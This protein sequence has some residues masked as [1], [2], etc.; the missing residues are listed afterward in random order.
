MDD[1]NQLIELLPL[2]LDLRAGQLWKGEQAIE[3]RPKPWNLML[4][5]A[6]RPGELL[7]KQEL[8]DAI[9]PDTYVSESSLNQAVKELR[10]ALGDDA[11]SPRFI[12]T[13]HRRGFRLIA[14][15]DRTALT[16]T[17]EDAKPEAPLFGRKMEFEVL[18]KALEAAR[19][20]N[21]QIVFITGEAGIG[22]TSL[23]RRFLVNLEQ[24]NDL[25]LGWG[26]CY[27]LHGESE[28]YLPVL[29][30]INRLAR[31]SHG[32]QVQWLL[33]QYAPSWHA[34]FPWML[35]PEHE[36]EP[37][38]L[39]STPARMLREFC[40][41]IG[42]LAEQAP[43]LLWLEDMHWSDAGTVDLLEAISRR[44]MGLRLLLITSYRP[45][46]AAVKDAPVARLKRSLEIGGL[47]QELPLEFLQLQT[48][49]QI[50]AHRLDSR[51]SPRL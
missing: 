6:Q 3:L 16:A 42:M 21:A 20:G 23:V 43:V 1:P 18:T 41:F 10:K 38:L 2:R 39:V 45:V 29:E 4:Y 36:I 37:Q 30:G 34:Q 12:E 7:S 27:D 19:R 40:D 11:R 5:M 25:A 35:N 13:V 15:N 14:P 9:W 44:E 48:V 46:D 17:G 51:M 28:P 8:M 32:K 47:A 31:G 24:A 33:R 50:V 49:Q 26:Q 22:K